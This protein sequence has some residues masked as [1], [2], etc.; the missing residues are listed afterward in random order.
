[1]K[2]SILFLTTANLATN[3]RLVK[4]LDLALHSGYYTKLIMFRLG[5]W[6]DDKTFLLLKDLENRYPHFDTLQDVTFLNATNENKFN[7]LLWGATEKLSRKLY[8]LF[9]NVRL[10]NAAANSRRAIQMLQKAKRIEQ[11]I[12]L[13][14]AHNLGALYP[15][16]HLSK[17]WKRPFTFDIEDYHPGENISFD[18]KNEKQR[19]KNLMKW[20]LPKAN[21][22]SFA[23]PL[24]Q[25]YTLN[26]IGGHKNHQVILNGFP[27]EEFT[28][29]GNEIP[30]NSAETKT[31]KLVW[32]SQKIGAGRGLEQMLEALSQL[33]LKLDQCIELTLIGGIDGR[34]KREV[35]DPFL[36]KTKSKKIK[37]KLSGPLSQKE[38][39]KN[40]AQFDI[41]LAIEFDSTDIN[42]Q[43]CITNK[44][45]AY[46]QAGLF[47]M[48]TNTKAQ[49]DFISAHPNL[50]ILCEQSPE[51]L[52][53]VLDRLFHILPEIK[54][55]ALKRYN[56]STVLSWEEEAEKV[57]KVWKN[58]SQ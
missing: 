22:L 32:F 8:P 3:P 43:L 56:E 29:P 47:L 42:R 20:L 41:G 21:A 36:K 26:L 24:I 44:I 52:T 6:S 5:N 19:R 11:N 39:H 46:A 17:K 13:I 23:S 34:F 27:Q 49:K 30:Q 1:M 18:A 48:A 50:G 10:I 16:Y 35:I 54:K 28:K 15:A 37:L 51:E 25:E 57:T 55:G 31:L 12:D 58:I 9:K 40:L 7:W 38:L 45:L 4:E 14:C 53:K 33:E 2:H